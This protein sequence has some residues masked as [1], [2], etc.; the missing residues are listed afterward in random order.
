[1]ISD[2][3]AFL[4]EQPELR[5]LAPPGGVAAGS[6][7]P[8]D[9][10]MR[11]PE[12]HRSLPALIDAL[13]S[14]PAIAPLVDLIPASV[15]DYLGCRR[16]VLYEIRDH[17]L[18]MVSSTAAVTARG[19][20][21]TLLR[22]G[23][24]EPIA[25]DEDVPETQALRD[26]DV[27]IVPSAPGAPRRIIA[28]MLGQG[29]AV[30]VLVIIPDTEAQWGTNG[31]P[32]SQM[33]L[34]GLMDVARVTG[35]I[36]ENAHLGSENRRRAEEMDLLTRLTNAFNNNVLDLD[37]AVMIVERQ[38]SRISHSDMCAVV[39]RG[40]GP[41]E[42]SKWLPPEIIRAIQA[43]T[44]LNDVRMWPL[45][46][47]LPEGVQS[48]YAFP[49]FADVRIVGVLALAFRKQ[50]HLLQDSER[51]LLAILANTASTV[52]QRTRLQRDAEHSRQQSRFMLERTQN[53]ERFQ[54]AILRNIQ[55]GIL[56]TDNEG[57]VTSLNPQGAALLGLGD[58]S[59]LGQPIEEVMP[60]A[61]AGLHLVRHGLG[62]R[63]VPQQ[64][65]VQ[66]RLAN[67]GEL[68]MGITIAPL[69]GADGTEMGV[70]C[71]FQDK[72]PLRVL[73]GEIR[74]LDNAATI[75]NEARMISHDLR[76]MLNSFLMGIGQIE[77]LVASNTEARQD[78]TYLHKE[79]NRMKALADNILY[80]SGP[81]PLQRGVFD[82]GELL[83]GITRVLM[84][85]AALSNV[86]MERQCEPGVTLFA[87]EMQI[88][89]AVENLAINAIEAMRGG[90]KL[91]LITRTTRPSAALHAPKAARDAHW[92]GPVE[93]RL[94]LPSYA[95]TTNETELLLPDNRQ[96]AVEID[97]IDTGPGI[98]AERLPHIWEMG[99]TFEKVAGHGLGLA[100]VKQIVDAHGGT[101]AVYTEVGHGTRFTLRLPAG[102]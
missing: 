37:A 19:Y 75:G 71:A 21:S 4:P 23:H 101:C 69:R 46:H 64:R 92:P 1:M 22:I 70:L 11:P 65:E 26:R 97:I 87:D 15:A 90:G 95:T 6:L 43:P 88:A 102:K 81:R 73:E 82:L 96:K 74:R 48:F 78:M 33:L 91:T 59:A 2:P 85:R 45:A 56:T 28:P 31:L 54:D 66:V 36:L 44:I 50:R 58:R 76:N 40:A 77:P 98:P 17:Y 18:H 52:L 24:V 32:P 93:P 83:E 14:R 61:E 20:T 9:P 8:H 35:I 10:R 63:R 38:V 30:G 49:L 27:I 94:Q 89:R 16:V 51:D 29:G 86:V 34:L 39:L 41:R 100:T 80:L 99:K 68:T 57:R 67:G 5:R 72:T 7:I 3:H 47:L 60:L 55:D 13:T 62:Q 12:G 79:I 25:L 42:S 53:Q 84:P